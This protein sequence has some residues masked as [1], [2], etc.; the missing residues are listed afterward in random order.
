MKNQSEW[1]A[2][3]SLDHC[4][5]RLESRHEKATLFAFDYQRRITV[6]V[7]PQDDN[8]YHFKVRRVQKNDFVFTHSPATVNGTLRRIDDQRTQVMA[9]SHVNPLATTLVPVIYG[10]MFAFFA[11]WTLYQP[12]EGSPITVEQV[13]VFALMLAAF[14]G[15]SYVFLAYWIES[16]SRLLVGMVHEVLGDLNPLL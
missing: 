14:S 5:Q 10:T 13:L 6:H 3:F 12:A 1:I 8:T 4:R 2:P 11:A 15:I 16:Q 9:A 7:S